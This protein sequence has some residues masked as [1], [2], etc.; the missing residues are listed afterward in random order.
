[1]QGPTSAFMLIESFMD[2]DHWISIMGIKC[3]WH[4]RLEHIRERPLG[5]PSQRLTN[6]KDI[7]FRKWLYEALIDTDKLDS[8]ILSFQ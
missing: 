2:I 6:I 7:V 8:H 5:C 1:M 3:E 4:V